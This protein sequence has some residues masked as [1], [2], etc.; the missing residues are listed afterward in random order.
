MGATT[1]GSASSSAGKKRSLGSVQTQWSRLLTALIG[2][3]GFGLEV[4][5]AIFDYRNLRG[6][7]RLVDHIM[8]GGI[9]LALTIV[10]SIRLLSQIRKVDG[11]SQS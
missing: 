8:L 2:A 11:P 9:F 5:R 7:A 4:D 1:T 6:E 10:S 3:F